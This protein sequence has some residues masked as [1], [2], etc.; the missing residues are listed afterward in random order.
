MKLK[1]IDIHERKSEYTRATGVIQNGENN[2]YP[3]LVERL[4]NSSPT[5]LGCVRVL[6][7]FMM[8]DGFTFE[9]NAQKQ[10]KL[11]NFRFDKS[12][13]YINKKGETP[14]VL[15]KKTAQTLAYQRGCFFHV[16]YN[17]LY[18][19]TS[20]QLMSYKNGRMGK[21][22]DDNYSGKIIFY[23]EWEKYPTKSKY[24]IFDVYNPNPK[25]VQTQV[26]KAGGWKNYKGQVFFLN[27]DQ[28]D[29]YPLT[30]V[31][32]ALIDC[33]SERQSSIFTNNG[34]KKGFFGKYAMFTQPFENDDDR[35]LF[36]GQLKK[37]VGVESIETVMHFELEQQSDKFEDTYKL[38]KIESNINDKTF[39]YS[40]KR[41]ARNIRIACGNIPVVLID[42]VEGKLGN[43]SGESY[44]EAQEFMQKQTVEERTMIEECFEEL[45]DNFHKNI[46]PT[47]LFTIEE[48]IKDE[49]I[50]KQTTD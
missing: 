50:S 31:D 3:Q 38:E 12:Q 34:F 2:D 35:R 43:T 4:I 8:G 46:T 37:G 15:L 42:E 30:F 48:I 33:D 6:S 29:N 32:A 23:D 11:N 22:D 26:E 24:E 36:R 1:A 25:V 5:A 9:N 10:A 17:A 44:R 39:E 20:V 14:N 27:L 28:N 18:Q 16:N 40:D 7:K 49:V 47:G 19:K 13:F 45:F 21:P 41:T